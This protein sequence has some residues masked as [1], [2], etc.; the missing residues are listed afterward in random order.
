MANLTGDRWRSFAFNDEEEEDLLTPDG[1]FQINEIDDLGR[2]TD[3][4]HERDQIKRTVYGQVSVMGPFLTILMEH[5]AFTGS[6]S[7]M[8]RYI[9]QLVIEED[10]PERLVIIAQRSSFDSVEVK[11]R[12]GSVIEG[13]RSGAEADPQFQDD[14]T[15]IITRP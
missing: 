12:G 8:S 6:S 2:I 4:Y 11:A 9:G 3:A 13:D 10:D 14:G 5:Q 1:V 7:K 15:I